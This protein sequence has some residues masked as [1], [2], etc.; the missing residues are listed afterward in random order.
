GRAVRGPHLE[1]ARPARP[2][3][4]LR[5]AR[6]RR[7]LPAAR[8]AVRRGGRGGVPPPGAPGPRAGGGHAGRGAR[9]P[10]RVDAA[11][12]HPQVG[13][14]VR[15][16]FRRVP[17]RPV[18][19]RTL[20]LA[21][22][23]GVLIGAGAAA[24]IASDLGVTPW[25]VLTTAVADRAGVS[26]GVSAAGLSVL[27]YALCAPLGRL[28]GWGNAVLLVAVSGAVDGAL[29]LLG[30]PDAWAGRAL[31]YAAGRPGRAARAGPGGHRGDGARRGHGA[32]RGAG[33]RRGGVR[34]GRRPADRRLAA[35]AGCRA[36]AA[37]ALSRRRRGT[38]ARRRGGC[39]APRSRGRRRCRPRAPRGVAGGV[40][41]AGRGA[42][43]ATAPA[44][45]RGGRAA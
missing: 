45:A 17:G 2:A 21:A 16:R 24:M 35:A 25:D 18:G 42:G 30:E 5:A 19:P 12:A 6:R 13:G 36:G 22:V 1:P 38:R 26:V 37:A 32:G 33:P 40:A 27:V 3:Q 14:R 44:R 41:R 43:A 11:P 4:A 29:A 15:V 10:G 8:R 20:A 39:A 34:A 28:P 31:L 23:G 7:L 9:R